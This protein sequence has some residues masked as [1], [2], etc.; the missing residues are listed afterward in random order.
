MIIYNVTSAEGRAAGEKDE[1]TGQKK[2][3]KKKQRYLKRG[4]TFRSFEH[5]YRAEG[6]ENHNDVRALLEKM[7]I[8]QRFLINT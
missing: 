7:L 8:I 5:H 4:V 2:K 1:D 3:G 6:N